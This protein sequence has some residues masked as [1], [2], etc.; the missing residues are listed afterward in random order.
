MHSRKWYLN[1][2]RFN[3]IKF[4]VLQSTRTKVNASSCSKGGLEQILGKKCFTE[5][6]IRHW[7]RL[8]REVVVPP[9]LK[10]SNGVWMLHLGMCLGIELTVLG[11]ELDSV[12]LE[13]FSDFSGSM[14]LWFLIC[15]SFDHKNC[16]FGKNICDTAMLSVFWTTFCSCCERCLENHKVSSWHAISLFCYPSWLAIVNCC[17]CNAILYTDYHCVSAFLI[18]FGFLRN[19][20][21]VKNSGPQSLTQYLGQCNQPPGKIMQE[22][23]IAGANKVSFPGHSTKWGLGGGYFPICFFS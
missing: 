2:M 23:L 5:K 18:V 20:F 19:N 22:S 11:S 12:T 10:C 7:K 13:V 9:S 4:Q 14:I 1:C 21:S 6:T 17:Y 3:K 16:W 8:L 15:F